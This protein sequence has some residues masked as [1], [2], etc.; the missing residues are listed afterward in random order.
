MRFYYQYL[1]IT[2]VLVVMMS[3]SQCINIKSN[4]QNKDQVK[5]SNAAGQPR[6]AW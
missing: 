4:M 5:A 6:P 1:L 3:Q 2:L